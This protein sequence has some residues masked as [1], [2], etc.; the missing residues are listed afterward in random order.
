MV[1][2]RRYL[3]VLD[4]DL[5]ALDE[6]LNL[7]PINYLVEQQEQE[8]CQV[9][10]LSLVDAGQAKQRRREIAFGGLRVIFFRLRRSS[11]HRRG[12]ATMSMPRPS[13]G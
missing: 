8:P 3:L 11:R 2:M 10:V 12:P 5:L 4:T 6:K 1:N 7:G 9:V 13:T